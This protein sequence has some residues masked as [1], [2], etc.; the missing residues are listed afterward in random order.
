[1]SHNST[2]LLRGHTC[3]TATVHTLQIAAEDKNLIVFQGGDMVGSNAVTELVHTAVVF[4]LAVSSGTELFSLLRTH[5]RGGLITAHE[6]ILHPVKHSHFGLPFSV[7][8]GRH[9]GG[10]VF[11]KHRVING[12]ADRHRP[13]IL[14]GADVGKIPSF[15][16]LQLV[17]Q[18]LDSLAGILAGG[19]FQSVGDDRNHCRGVLV[20]LDFRQKLVQRDAHRI[21]QRGRAARNVLLGCQF[22][23]FFHRDIFVDIRLVAVAE[24]K[25]GDEVF[26]RIL[27]AFLCGADAAH[28]LVEARNGRTG[29]TVHRSAL[30][31]DDEIVNFQFFVG[32]FFFF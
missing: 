32:F 21:I 23:D 25:Q 17:N 27:V 16:V 10:G 19:I 5:R 8:S 6:V 18:R 13:H 2:E 30:V 11:E 15:F 28:G 31:E 12:E 14:I 4:L 3:R 9:A 26:L 22:F 20:A 1:M 24:D 7:P 29:N